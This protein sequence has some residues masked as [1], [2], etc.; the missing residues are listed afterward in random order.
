MNSSTNY[1]TQITP[2]TSHSLTSPNVTSWNS[3]SIFHLVFLLLRMRTCLMMMRMRK[4]K[5]R[6]RK[7]MFFHHLHGAIRLDLLPLLHFYPYNL[8]RLSHLSS[9]LLISFL[10]SPYISFFFTSLAISSTRSSKIVL[11]GKRKNVRETKKETET[12]REGIETKNQKEKEKKKETETETEIGMVIEIERGEIETEKE[13]EKEIE[14]IGTEE[15][16]TETEIGTGMVTEIER[17][18]EIGIG[19]T[20]TGMVTEIEI[21][22]EGVMKKERE[23]V[24]VIVMMTG[25]TEEIENVTEMMRGNAIEPVTMKDEGS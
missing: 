9:S 19:E 16:E 21:G 22:G 18:K 4:K 14:M 15:I 1:S 23:N 5:K 2:A 11:L 25:E 20:E 12:G 17:G 3:L 10:S 13:I 7:S 8:S 6:Q 24:I